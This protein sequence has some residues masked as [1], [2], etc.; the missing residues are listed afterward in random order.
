MVA[1]QAPDEDD[2]TK[3]EEEDPKWLRRRSTEA[4]FPALLLLRL[5]ARKKGEF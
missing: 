3:I 5:L 1:E 4:Q 2:E